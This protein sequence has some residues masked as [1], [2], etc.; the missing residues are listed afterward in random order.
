MSKRPVGR[1]IAK[2][3]QYGSPDPRSV[4]DNLRFKAF[5]VLCASECELLCQLPTYNS[6][7]TKDTNSQV[8]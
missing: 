5:R 1:R 4:V 7:K 8:H 6:G 3:G 2:A